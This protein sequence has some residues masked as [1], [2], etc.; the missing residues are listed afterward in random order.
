MRAEDRRITL[1]EDLFHRLFNKHRAASLKALLQVFPLAGMHEISSE[2]F[3]EKIPDKIYQSLNWKDD[4]RLFFLDLTIEVNPEDIYKMNTYRSW[5]LEQVTRHLPRRRKYHEPEERVHGAL[6][7]IMAPEDEDRMLAARYHVEVLSLQEGLP[8]DIP[9]LGICR[10]RCAIR[11][12]K[13]L[14]A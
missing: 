1:K 6:L 4:P 13:G 7:S 11:A 14:L 2:I 8:L 5:G 12:W 9:P 10:S 3:P